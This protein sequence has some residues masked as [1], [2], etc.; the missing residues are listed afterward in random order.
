MRFDELKE[1]SNIENDLEFALLPYYKELQ[2][3]RGLGLIMSGSGSSYFK[4]GDFDLELNDN[5]EVF[6][7]LEALPYG[8][9]EV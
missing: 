5:Y 6:K 7:E 9:I 3:L 1:I 4:I 2:Y 8:V